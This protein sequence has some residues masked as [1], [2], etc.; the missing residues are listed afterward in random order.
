MQHTP[1]HT[2]TRL[3]AAVF[4]TALCALCA[5][6]QFRQ[7]V[8]YR[9]VSSDNHIIAASAFTFDSVDEPPRFPGGDGELLK[10]INRERRYPRAA[11]ERKI[12]GRV[13]LSF[14]VDQQGNIANPEILRSV[15]DD[16]DTEA[17]RILA[18]MPRWTPG[19]IAD[20]P[21]PVYCILAIPFR[22]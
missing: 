19:R 17:L 7:V 4:L 20:I 13:L 12:Q 15:D 1:P 5:N 6:A 2:A 22:L 11:Y 9:T 14:I 10:F 8:T 16:L 18:E 21:V 3:L